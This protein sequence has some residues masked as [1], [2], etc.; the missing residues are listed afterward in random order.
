MV[1]FIIGLRPCG[2]GKEDILSV[3]TWVWEFFLATWKD[4]K[5]IVEYSCRGLLQYTKLLQVASI[6]LL[7]TLL[8]GEIHD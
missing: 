6:S 5:D 7:G 1:K 2:A 8:W 4:M 3:S